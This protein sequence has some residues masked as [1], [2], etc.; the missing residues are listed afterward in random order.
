VD[1]D[2]GH[3]VSL[4]TELSE[5]A[6]DRS[7]QQH[8]TVGIRGMDQDARLYVDDTLMGEVVPN[9]GSTVEV[10]A[11]VY[12]AG[13]NGPTTFE[14]LELLGPRGWQ[15]TLDV[16][17]LGTTDLDERYITLRAYQDY[18]QDG[19]SDPTV[20]TSAVWLGNQGDSGLPE[21]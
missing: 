2:R 6:L 17:E 13:T 3:S 19:D 8:H 1:P 10:E 21:P 5:P 18:E 12:D 15:K 9:P 7:F 20:M 16:D 11:T 14:K 4:M